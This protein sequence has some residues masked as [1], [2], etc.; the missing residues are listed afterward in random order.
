MEYASCPFLVPV[1]C[2][3]LWVRPQPA[4]C[5]P[6]E[7][8]VRVPALRTLRETCTTPAHENCPAY[9]VPRVQARLRGGGT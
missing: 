7:G 9:R 8:R 1:V 2:D 5:R 4:Y 6:P 3:R